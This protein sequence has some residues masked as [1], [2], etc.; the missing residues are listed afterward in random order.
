MSE[1][2]TFPILSPMDEQ[3]FFFFTGNFRANYRGKRFM[4]PGASSNAGEP[5]QLGWR[6]QAYRMDTV[7]Q[8]FHTTALFDYVDV[9]DQ[10][11]DSFMDPSGTSTLTTPTSAFTC[12]SAHTCF[13]TREAWAE[14]HIIS[15]RAGPRHRSPT[16]DPRVLV[17]GQL[18]IMGAFADG[19]LYFA[20]S[21]T[22]VANP[23]ARQL[24]QDT[25]MTFLASNN[26]LFES[27][28][29]EYSVN[30]S[31]DANATLTTAIP[32]ATCYITDVASYDI[33]N[34][35]GVGEAA[36]CQL[37]VD[38]GGV[39]SCSTMEDYHIACSRTV[40][41]VGYSTRLVSDDGDKATN[42]GG[43]FREVPLQLHFRTH[44]Y[45]A[46]A[47]LGPLAT[48]GV[49]TSGVVFYE[50]VRPESRRC[51]F[52]VRAPGIATVWIA[53]T[54]M[55]SNFVQVSAK[56]ASGDFELVA[57]CGRLKPFAVSN[58]N[59][60]PVFGQDGLCGTFYPCHVRNVS[61]GTQ[62][63]VELGTLSR[64]RDCNYSGVAYVE[65]LPTTIASSG[66]ENST[67]LEAANVTGLED[68]S[69]YLQTATGEST[70]LRLFLFNASLGVLRVVQTAFSCSDRSCTGAAPIRISS[71]TMSDSG[72]LVSATPLGECGGAKQFPAGPGLSGQCALAYDCT[73]GFMDFKTMPF[74]GVVTLD[75]DAKFLR[76]ATNNYTLS[77]YCT[78]F[79]ANFFG[80]RNTSA[81]WV[82]TFPL[83][84]DESTSTALIVRGSSTDELLASLASQ[85]LPLVKL[86]TFGPFGEQREALYA[87]WT[88]IDI[89]SLPANAT[90]ACIADF[91]S[92]AE[93]RCFVPVPTNATYVTVRV[94]QSD[95]AANSIR[96]R[97]LDASGIADE[98]KT[99]TCG[100]S[101]GFRGAAG[102]KS[103]C[104]SYLDC[105]AAFLYPPGAVEGTIAQ[106][107]LTVP[108]TL[109]ARDCPFALASTVEFTARVTDWTQ[110]CSGMVCVADRS[111]VPLAQVCDGFVADCSDL[112]DETQC[113]HWHV[114]QTDF[115][116][117]QLPMVHISNSTALGCRREAVA[118]GGEAFSIW[119]DGDCFVLSQGTSALFRLSPSRYL[120]SAP[121]ATVH[122][123]VNEPSEYRKCSAL[124]HCSGNGQLANPSSLD[125]DR[126]MCAC[127]ADF[128]GSDCSIL[129]TIGTVATL[130]AITPRSTDAFVQAAYESAL[131]AG[132]RAVAVKIS[133]ALPFNRSHVAIPF[134]YSSFDLNAAATFRNEIF[135]DA[136]L[137][138]INRELSGVRQQ[139]V[140]LITGLDGVNSFSSLASCDVSDDQPHVCYS[141][142][143][144]TAVG[145]LLATAY[146]VQGFDLSYGTSGASAR[147]AVDDSVLPCDADRDY[148]AAT[149]TNLL[150]PCFPVAC[151]TN[152]I[153]Y[154]SGITVAE[155][156][157]ARVTSSSCTTTKTID[158][159]ATSA[160]AV[161]PL[162]AV[163]T[164]S[165][166]SR[167][168]RAYLDGAGG[169][170]A[171]VV[172]CLVFGVAMV[173]IALRTIRG[174]RRRIGKSD[175]R[176][177]GTWFATTMTTA[178]VN[179]SSR[180]DTEGLAIGCFVLFA[181]VLAVVG[182]LFV[183]F[184]T[185]TV[186]ESNFAVVV[187]AFPSKACSGTS[188][189][190]TL[191]TKSALVEATGECKALR[192][193]G[194][195][196][197]TVFAHAI[198][199][200]D[201]TRYIPHV[202]FGSTKGTCGSAPTSP[203]FDDCISSNTLLADAIGF[204]RLSC[205]TL[206]SSQKFIDSLE[207]INPTV[208]QSVTR[209]TMELSAATRERTLN[210]AD[211]T[212]AYARQLVASRR[213]MESTSH[214][215]NV[216]SSIHSPE[217]FAARVL[218]N[219][220]VMQGPD[221]YRSDVSSY[222]DPLE[223]WLTPVQ[224]NL[225]LLQL[226]N[227]T[228]KALDYPAGFVFGAFQSVNEIRGSA[229]GP[230]A[231][232]YYGAKASA[233]DIGSHFGPK[234]SAN[235]A[236]FTIS[237]W[238]RASNTTRGFAFIV[239]DIFEDTET[240]QSLVVDQLLNIAAQGETP[241][242]SWFDHSFHVYGA[243]YV[244][245]ASKQMQFLM[246]N[247]EGDGVVRALWDLEFLN[248]THTMNGRWHHVTVGIRNAMGR[249]FAV[250]GIDGK[251]SLSQVG[252]GKCLPRRPAPITDAE[253]VMAPRGTTET[254]HMAMRGGAIYVGYFNGGVQRLRFVPQFES[255]DVAVRSG[256]REMRVQASIRVTTAMSIFA[257]MLCFAI[258]ALFGIGYH[259]YCLFNESQELDQLE[260]DKM[261]ATFSDHRETLFATY[262]PLT[263]S[264][265]RNFARTSDLVFGLL[266]DEC[267][268]SP[269]V[270]DDD[271]TS[272][273]LVRVLFARAHPG[274]VE[275]AMPTPGEWRE[276]VES[277]PD[278]EETYAAAQRER[279]RLSSSLSRG[280]AK[281]A[282]PAIMTVI[283][284][285]QASGIYV[286]TWTTP[287]SYK[288]TIGPFLNVFTIDFFGD[289]AIVGPLVQLTCAVLLMAAIAFVLIKDESRFFANVA[290]YQ[291]RRDEVLGL[292][293]GAKGR[294]REKV[295]RKM[296]PDLFRV[297]SYAFKFSEILVRPFLRVKLQGLTAG[298]SREPVNLDGAGIAQPTTTNSATGNGNVV[299]QC[300]GR[301]EPL[302]WITHRCHE[303]GCLLLPVEQNDV[304]PYSNQRQCCVVE[305]GRERCETSTGRLWV[306]F[307]T[308][309]TRS[310][311][312]ACSYAICEAHLNTKWY[313]KAALLAYAPMRRRMRQ[314]PGWIMMY[315]A[316]SA[317]VALYTPV[318]RTCLMILACHP[319]YQCEFPQCWAMVDQKFGAAVYL[320]IVIIIGYGTMYPVSLMAMLLRRIWALNEVFKSPVYNGEFLMPLPMEIV[321][322]V[323]QKKCIYDSLAF[324]A[325]Q[326]VRHRIRTTLTGSVHTQ[327]PDDDEGQETAACVVLPDSEEGA[328]RTVSVRFTVEPQE[329]DTAKP[330]ILAASASRRGSRRQS[331]ALK[332]H[333]IPRADAVAAA[334]WERFLLGD[335]SALLPLY[336]AVKFERI[337]LVPILHC[338]KFILLIPPILLEPNSFEQLVFIAVGEVLY[339]VLL[340]GAAPFASRWLLI[341]VNI[342]N[343]HQFILVALQGYY[344]AQLNDY[345]ASST[346]SPLMT[347]TTIIYTLVSVIVI[348]AM[349]GMPV[350]AK[351]IAKLVANR[352]FRRFGLPRINTIL[353]YV[354]PGG[355]VRESCL[356]D[357]PPPPMSPAE[358]CF[359]VAPLSSQESGPSN[360]LNP[361]ADVELI[362][363]DG[364]VYV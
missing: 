203:V 195:S 96:V 176:H 68:R 268:T 40:D 103:D 46:L 56:S 280:G 354:C 267:I 258:I 257:A 334:E 128:T 193:V 178:A 312:T 309:N 80:G 113:S 36:I 251:S 129:K 7:V 255:S 86:F 49:N 224:K 200:Q 207:A 149:R 124:L 216:I 21:R 51:D 348:M 305:A 298:A 61:Q 347:A 350:A 9:A 254:R 84:T 24:R 70:S 352:M 256:T 241:S 206:E 59:G 145:V 283:A 1:T 288:D 315:A 38:G 148:F 150:T 169:A 208:P 17:F 175:L 76:A 65:L 108:N 341:V 112:S 164:P 185:S 146:G 114:V 50:K 279:K 284:T 73:H 300:D 95:F 285:L 121:G 107:E 292:A 102:A 189:L 355:F 307:H 6:V 141:S 287:G 293:S 66:G 223:Q 139:P 194:D 351:L 317:A 152:G 261:M 89:P 15:F 325:V 14:S 138:S 253:E 281:A 22:V 326:A 132:N 362:D 67:T 273:K 214:E 236:G 299:V 116:L 357:S 43:S 157:S 100:G 170:I 296:A 62:L 168:T 349:L 192:F 289:N 171:V 93:H 209:R 353:L 311:E 235:G 295:L 11:C 162:V 359:A 155:N 120:A 71:A 272:A 217:Y 321:D 111:C 172:V 101:R 219:R 58:A 4:V 88:A 25:V 151:A 181:V 31:G 358:D 137:Q 338:S 303:H 201:G 240:L 221:T 140:T 122:V 33:R 324:R 205:A 234:H 250:L 198:C 165:V 135:S 247:P 191:P 97:F 26:S 136:T 27:P 161:E 106:I 313:V 29:F 329:A 229:A 228:S 85:A 316:M 158:L 230:F 243:L 246:A 143:R 190:K 204:W 47:K 265:A 179:T 245:G 45:I 248:Q 342:S 54:I 211:G 159:L 274:K 218:G 41:C 126:C 57:E 227:V 336:E 78:A 239:A 290:R 130:V 153:D 294:Q 109:K 188:T 42:V 213:T 277:A 266:L 16:C 278:D 327:N 105:V 160:T 173:L 335:A 343:L 98:D 3:G 226:R 320:C 154:I 82:P 2:L 184:A 306:C 231:H 202:A 282:H 147:R 339:A 72:E 10:R 156:V 142:N 222:L 269:L 32:G 360:S 301:E 215:P 310:S 131:A 332:V 8:L 127:D 264:A 177:T 118:R 237:L 249:T 44:G 340:S 163:G 34:G 196:D 319:L 75:I 331:V 18:A 323:A 276:L 210:A 77:S 252:W 64:Q 52:T 39:S 91:V 35:F 115:A 5:L 63:R 183:L 30:T 79:N 94:S 20:A 225:P 92:A 242:T 318:M 37:A 363:E 125:G 328:D 297:V 346:L 361:F 186:K 104:S 110:E 144:T 83:L 322:E 87:N 291:H 53:Q 123:R 117:A 260:L 12:R 233:F 212:T 356:S 199:V 308:D 134:T 337:W 304:I 74:T 232:R 99:V 48:F 69:L 133:N 302:Y 182:L 262:E 60:A 90:F 364:H 333:S 180:V 187:Q 119:P 167:W 270:D 275:A 238:L 330:M 19:A 28:L 166:T 13:F 174:A 314:G 259:V 344:V 55:A 263:F 81:S 197:A 286:S 23:V 345:D 244:D 271:P 220:F